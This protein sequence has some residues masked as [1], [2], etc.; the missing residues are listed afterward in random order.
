MDPHD[1]NIRHL[2]AHAAIVETG[3]ISEAARRINLSQPSVTQAIAKLESQLGV[4]LFRRRPTGMQP[5]KSGRLLAQRADAM[6]RLL[7]NGRVTAAQMRCFLAL[8][9]TGSYSAAA[10]ALAMAQPSVHRAVT[11]LATNLETSLVERVGRSVFLTRGGR[12]MVRQFTLALAELDAA[13]VELAALKG[14][15][16]GRIAIGAMPLSRAKLLPLALASFHAAHPD[17]RLVIVEGSHAELAGPLRDGVIAFMVGA[18]RQDPGS[19]L[20]NIPL[21]NDAPMI[22]GR[23]DH[24]LEGTSRPTGG[25]LARYPWLVPPEGTPLRALWSKMFEKLGVDPPDVTI[26]VGSV[27]M[28][29]QLLVASDHLTLLSPDQAT[30]EFEA[31]WLTQI[32]LT[33]TGLERTIG[34]T[35]RRDWRPTVLELAFLDMLGSAAAQCGRIISSKN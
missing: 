5:T 16:T 18:L 31:G 29:R 2:S 1:L 21:F 13:L 10:R 7:G 17:V 25:D 19:D 6:M 9:R 4:S 20:A 3:S 8:A 22:V 15:D 14:Q 30:V 34:I 35:T 24:P 27:M 33:P 23:V 32:G 26:E 28:I 11:D 12:A